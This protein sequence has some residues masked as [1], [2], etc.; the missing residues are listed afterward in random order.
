[1]GVDR[2]FLNYLPHNEARTIILDPAAT[3]I[4]D[5]GNIRPLDFISD[6]SI[7]CG[8]D[9]EPY[10]SSIYIGLELVTGII[11]TNSIPILA[12]TVGKKEWNYGKPI[13]LSPLEDGYSGWVTPGRLNIV[14]LPVVYRYSTPAQSKLAERC[15][16][17]FQKRISSVVCDKTGVKLTGLVKL[18]AGNGLSLQTGTSEDGRDQLFFVL[19]DRLKKS[20]ANG[21]NF[22]DHWQEAPPHNVG[23]IGGAY[24][25]MDGL[26]NIVFEGPF[27]LIRIHD[28]ESDEDVGAAISTDLDTSDLC[29]YE[30]PKLPEQPDL[31][32]P[33]VELPPI[34]PSYP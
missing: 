32:E 24:A 20:L 17:R 21:V 26:L 27:T 1:M 15:L 13:F 34:I 2:N 23:S 5:M 25:D 8:K 3:G 4:D 11:M 12:F 7:G 29:D 18:A 31:P 28:S 6:L 19:E 16:F 9:D 10:L 14:E 30:K 22:I 33:C